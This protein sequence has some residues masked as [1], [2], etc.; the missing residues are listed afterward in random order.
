LDVASKGHAEE[1]SNS[2]FLKA[3]AIIALLLLGIGLITV[4]LVQHSK[5]KAAN[6]SS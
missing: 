6:S 2:G 1:R 5:K 4:Y 3:L